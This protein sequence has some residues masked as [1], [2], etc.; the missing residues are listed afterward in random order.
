MLLNGD[1]VFALWRI[2]DRSRL[3]NAPTV[4]SCDWLWSPEL[5]EVGLMNV[6]TCQPLKNILKQK[7]TH[8]K[9]KNA[10]KWRRSLWRLVCLGCRRDCLWPPYH[11]RDRDS[12]LDGGRLLLEHQDYRE[13]K[14]STWH[15]LDK[16]LTL[17]QTWR[18]EII[19]GPR[20][21]GQ[22]ALCFC[23]GSP[24]M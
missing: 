8:L 15:Q 16:P 14:G 2:D 21:Y 18:R 11:H 6:M 9:K 5:D 12:V 22:P 3:Q 1:S 23:P 20:D 10:C 4:N 13:W 17:R 7:A 24:Q 19:N